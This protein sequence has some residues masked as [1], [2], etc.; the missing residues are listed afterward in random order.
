MESLHVD[1]FVALVQEKV[2]QAERLVEVPSGVVTQVDDE[3]F[4]PLVEKCLAGFAELPVG[5]L[6]E[7]CKPDVTGSPVDH[8]TGVDAVD[9]DLSPCDL[10]GNLFFPPADGDGH[11]GPGRAFHPADHA[12]L[13]ELHPGDHLV[14]HFKEP[15]S[16]QETGLLRRP[17]LDHFDHRRRVVRD[18][19]LDAY[20]LEVA[21]E[22]HVSLCQF[23]RRHV[24]GMRVQGVKRSLDG[25]IGDILDVYGVHVVLADLVE[26]VV[27]LLPLVVLYVEQGLSL[28]VGADCHGK[29]DSDGYAKDRDPYWGIFLHLEN[30]CGKLVYLLNFDTGPAQ[31]VHP[32]GEAVFVLVHDPLDP[33]LYDQFRT[34]QARGCRHVKRGTVA[35]VP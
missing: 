2:A 5:R 18:V 24:H 15:V 26:D 23:H 33:C 20:A 21:G 25:G 17:S 35:A 28:P 3:F 8:E 27:Q 22:F 9:G 31:E 6:G 32:V 12:V 14:V 1:D 30:C 13:R 34:L 4:H 11:L 16:G 10:E 7:L 19:E 29:Q